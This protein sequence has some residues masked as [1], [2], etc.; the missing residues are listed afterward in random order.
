MN[1]LHIV[2]RQHVVV[3]VNLRESFGD[4]KYVVNTSDSFLCDRDIMD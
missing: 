4:H 3:V 1:S 2:I